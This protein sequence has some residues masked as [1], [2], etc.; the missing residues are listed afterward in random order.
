MVNGKEKRGRE[1]VAGESWE[2]ANIKKG[3]PWKEASGYGQKEKNGKRKKLPKGKLEASGRAKKGATEEESWAENG[4]EELLIAAA[5]KAPLP[6]RQSII[7][8]FGI[9]PRENIVSCPLPFNFCFFPNTNV[10]S[11][12]KHVFSEFAHRNVCRLYM[13]VKHTCYL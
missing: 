11:S 4:A 1:K 6:H 13:I 7:A 8:A 5:R 3:E 10:G 2:K 9:S 12:Q